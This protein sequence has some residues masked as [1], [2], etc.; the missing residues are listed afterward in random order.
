MIANLPSLPPYFLF[1]TQTPN[2]CT[3]SNFLRVFI[4]FAR[5]MLR[6]K[7][8]HFPLNFKR[9]PHQT[10]DKMRH[11]STVRTN[12]WM[13]MTATSFIK[14][15]WIKLTEWR[16]KTISN[17]QYSRIDCVARKRCGG[18]EAA[19][20]ADRLRIQWTNRR[21]RRWRRR[22]TQSSLNAFWRSPLV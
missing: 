17:T 14:S 9:A 7:N 4:T 13:W 10:P 3:S 16:N 15:L 12:E 11:P 20:A 8:I 18:R 22:K 1:I 5:W 19:V 6:E 2:I 21:R